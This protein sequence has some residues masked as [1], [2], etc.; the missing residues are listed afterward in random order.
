M[1]PIRQKTA[2][3]CWSR[4]F[5]NRILEILVRPQRLLNCQNY[6]LII[7]GTTI[8]V[9]FKIML[10]ITNISHDLIVTWMCFLIPS[11]L[12]FTLLINFLSYLIKSYLDS[13]MRLWVLPIFPFIVWPP[14]RIFFSL[15]FI[16]RPPL[17][18]IFHLI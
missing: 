10:S 7:R 11:A 6:G 3:A 14:L 18:D 16:T 1:L 13:V 5:T 4:G 9:G 12:L 15:A 8:P 17:L 2:G